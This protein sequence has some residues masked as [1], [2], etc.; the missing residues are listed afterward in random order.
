MTRF[1]SSLLASVS[2]LFLTSLITLSLHAADKPASAFAEL[3]AAKGQ[4]VSGKLEFTQEAGAVHISGEVKHLS[5]GKHGIH[6][7]DKADLS[8]PDLASAG[9]HFN[10]TKEAHGAPGAAHHHAGDFGNITADENGTA[11]VDLTISGLSL[12]GPNS[13]VGHSI[14]I[15]GA[16]DDL[17]SQPS[18]NSGPRVAGGVIEPNAGL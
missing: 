6:V 12:T 5:P 3:K 16:A 1:T 2:T 17:K 15:H 13:I 14:I 7:H 10:P 18:G 8:A 4:T 11:H 9:G